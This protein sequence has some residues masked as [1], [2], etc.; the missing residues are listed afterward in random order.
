MNAINLNNSIKF[1]PLFKELFILQY[2]LVLICALFLSDIGGLIIVANVALWLFHILFSL[3]SSFYSILNYTFIFCNGL[4]NY[5]DNPLPISNSKGFLIITLGSFLFHSKFGKSPGYKLVFIFLYFSFITTLLSTYQKSWD[6]L[7]SMTSMFINILLLLSF[8]RTRKDIQMVLTLLA[9]SLSI[10]AAYS[11]HLWMNTTSQTYMI[12]ELL[13]ETS[14][15]QGVIGS[16][17]LAAY[18]CIFMAYLFFNIRNKVNISWLHVGL[19]SWLLLGLYTAESRGG[20]ILFVLT[21][22][23][24]IFKS[25]QIS[26]KFKLLL[27]LLAAIVGYIMFLSGYGV[28]NKFLAIFSGT[29]DGSSSIRLALIFFAFEAISQFP[30]TGLGLRCFS[31]YNGELHGDRWALS[32]HNFYLEVLTSYG[33]ILGGILIIYVIYL[34]LRNSGIKDL[35]GESLYLG[36]V[37]MLIGGFSGNY[38]GDRLFFIFVFLLYLNCHLAKKKKLAL[39]ND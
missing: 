29:L 9:L 6:E 27:L 21:L 13:I 33:V 16:N 8:I 23:Y 12:G 7:I 20:M 14:R 28:I 37:L 1:D 31:V 4:I 32:P 15:Q 25:K 5:M 18:C 26:V 35:L 30:F 2:F 17:E 19:I 24:I 39:S 34:V 10:S 22:S 11:F 38:F 3:R 36:G